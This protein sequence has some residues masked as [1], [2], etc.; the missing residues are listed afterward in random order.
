M[1]MG[2]SFLARI[3]FLVCPDRTCFYDKKVFALTKEIIDH[4]DHRTN[5]PE[6]IHLKFGL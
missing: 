6:T 5:G 2:I 3:V 1:M 4:H